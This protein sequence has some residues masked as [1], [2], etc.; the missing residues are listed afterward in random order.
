[1]GIRVGNSAWEF[2]GESKAGKCDGGDKGE[3]G[4]SEGHRKIFRE[5]GDQISSGESGLTNGQSRVDFNAH[6]LH[7]SNTRDWN[8]YRAK[9]R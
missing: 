5:S 6:V 1:M 2:G 9:L 4:G 3:V 7:S 8:V